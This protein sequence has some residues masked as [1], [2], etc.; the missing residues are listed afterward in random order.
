MGSYCC[1][2]KSAY[3]DLPHASLCTVNVLKKTN[4]S[5]FNTL[6]CVFSSCRLQLPK[7]SPNSQELFE[8][9]VV[10][11]YSFGE[12]INFTVDA[13]GNQ[14]QP[15]K[16]LWNFLMTVK[17]HFVSNLLLSVERL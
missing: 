17:E 2:L 10:S 16:H 8:M 14:L 15:A 12:S 3:W 1:A 6:I 4:H 5:F 11:T 13:F 9:H 7:W